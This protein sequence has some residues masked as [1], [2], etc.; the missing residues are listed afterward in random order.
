MVR[1]WLDCDHVLI[2]SENLNYSANIIR[3]DRK[4]HGE[5]ILVYIIVNIPFK[6][7]VKMY[8]NDCTVECLA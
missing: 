7:V 8:I 5:G 6:L 1:L 4:S 2:I 3:C